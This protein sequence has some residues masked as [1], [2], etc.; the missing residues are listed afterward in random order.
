MQVSTPV[1]KIVFGAVLCMSTGPAVAA[2][3][4]LTQPALAD[5]SC[6]VATVLAVHQRICNC[7][8]YR[9]VQ[10]QC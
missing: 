7:I 4:L 6:L 8:S 2:A 10:W 9:A 1:G 3:A 5:A